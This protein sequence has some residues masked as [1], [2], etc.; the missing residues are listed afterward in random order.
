[1][2][3][4]YYKPWSKLYDHPSKGN[5]TYDSIIKFL[6]NIYK[7]QIDSFLDLYLVSSRNFESL[8]GLGASLYFYENLLLTY[9]LEKFIKSNLLAQLGAA[10]L[11]MTNSEAHEYP[12]IIIDHNYNPG[13]YLNTL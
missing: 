4:T 6:D 2:I 9:I 5:F 1:V 12:K 11:P 13:I 7:E 8:A 3:F 10:H